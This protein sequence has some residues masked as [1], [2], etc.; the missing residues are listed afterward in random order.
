MLSAICRI[1]FLE[2]VRAFFAEG[3]RRATAI[4]AM[5][6]GFM[7]DGPGGCE[8]AADLVMVGAETRIDVRRAT[9]CTG[10]RKSEPLRFLKE[11]NILSAHQSSNRICPATQSVSAAHGPCRFDRPAD[12]LPPRRR[13]LAPL[14][15]AAPARSAL[16]RPVLGAA[17][18]GQATL[19]WMR[20]S[21]GPVVINWPSTTTRP[22][23]APQL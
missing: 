19:P 4:A 21:S 22:P 14:R 23:C 6:I 17:E 8:R 16:A 7:V 3:R 13:T 1:C 20:I 10:L 15:S 5:A 2:W 12:R 18:G 9:V 11:M